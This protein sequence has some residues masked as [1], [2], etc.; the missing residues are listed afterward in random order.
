[1]NFTEVMIFVAGVLQF[2]VAGYALFLNR[3]FG[4]SRVGWSLVWAFT[5]LALIHLI[6]SARLFTVEVQPGIEIEAIYSLIALLMLTGMVHLGTVLKERLSLERMEHQMRVEL[7]SEVKKKTA[8]LVRAIEGLQSE[9]DERK[10]MEG[11]VEKSNTELF[12]ANRQIKTASLATSVLYH[13]RAMLKSVN[14]SANLVSDQ[15]KQSKIAN[16]V[17]IGALIREHAADLGGF[18]THDPRG[19]KLPQYI[20]ELAS[21]LAQEQADLSRELESLKKNLE[22][23]MA[24]QQNYDKFT[25]Q[26]DAAEVAGPVENP[27]VACEPEPH[28]SEFDAKLPP[29]SKV[30]FDTAF[31]AHA[32][33]HREVN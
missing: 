14:A 5:L 15:M 16:V 27:P 18:M 12:F 3:L 31:L 19:Q 30:D 32:A 20:A 17:R 6:Q 11:E 7:E 24:L 13:V 22:R 10:R 26:G 9:M 23:I 29:A 4:T 2:I 25:W 33:D 28:L 21:H 8:Y 1:M